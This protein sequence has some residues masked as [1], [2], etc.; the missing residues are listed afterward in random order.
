MSISLKRS[1]RREDQEVPAITHKLLAAVKE[2]VCHLVDTGGMC[3]HSHYGCES[4][5]EKKA[6]SWVKN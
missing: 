3:I 1:F 4:W 6:E 5:T 2:R